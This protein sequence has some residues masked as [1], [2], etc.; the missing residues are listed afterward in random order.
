[1]SEFMNLILTKGR[2]NKNNKRIARCGQNWSG[3]MYSSESQPRFMNKN[4][5]IQ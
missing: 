5:K 1:M 4:L 3:F 2:R